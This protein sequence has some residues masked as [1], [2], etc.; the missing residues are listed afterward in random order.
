MV[1]MEKWVSKLRAEGRN[2]SPMRLSAPGMHAYW[3]ENSRLDPRGRCCKSGCA[4]KSLVVPGCGG[5][6]TPN[7]QWIK[8]RK[9]Q[10]GKYSPDVIITPWMELPRH[11]GREMEANVVTDADSR[12]IAWP[13][14]HD[15][16]EERSEV[17]HRQDY[18]DLLRG[19]VRWPRGRQN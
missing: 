4:I 19:L 6:Q 12:G 15:T 10:R 1:P 11:S 8:T 7:I 17:V 13:S 14:G 9:S 2:V 3:V 18:D 5:I 16:A